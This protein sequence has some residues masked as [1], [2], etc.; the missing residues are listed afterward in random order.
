MK[1]NGTIRFLIFF[2]ITSILVVS[3]GDSHKKTILVPNGTEINIS[4]FD[5]FIEKQLSKY[6]VPGL[7]IAI[8]NGD[9]IVYSKTFGVRSLKNQ[10]KSH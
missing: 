6:E 5:V 10:K 9:Q 3:C 7:G 1:Y 8:L 2:L 4:D